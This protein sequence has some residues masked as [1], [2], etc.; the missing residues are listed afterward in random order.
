MKHL[1]WVCLVFAQMITVN[2]VFAQDPG[3]GFKKNNFY[4]A[5]QGSSEEAIDKQL[6]LLKTTDIPGKGAYEGALLMKKADIVNGAKKKLYLFKE[7]H[8]KLEAV[9][10]KD[11]SNTEF[12]FLRFMIQEHAPGV[13]GYKGEREKD[14]RYIM[15]NFAKLSPVVQ[16]AVREY[17]K[18][19]IFLK[20]ADF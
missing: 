18:K 12:R 10:N 7:G 6:R 2:L 17:S 1:G 14:S 4:N 19:S 20:P 8:R 3:G 13:L 15:K 16:Q 9:L 5:V 11:S